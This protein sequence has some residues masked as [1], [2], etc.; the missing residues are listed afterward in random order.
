[1]Y[2]IRDAKT[3]FHTEQHSIKEVSYALGF[4]YPNHF[5]RF[6]KE[7]TGMTPTAWKDLN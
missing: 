2:E 6:F 5:S 7:K 4:E 1:M 3:L